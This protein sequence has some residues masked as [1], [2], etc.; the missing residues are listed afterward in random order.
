MRGGRNAALRCALPGARVLLTALTV[1]TATCML[2]M[3]RAVELHISGELGEAETPPQVVPDLALREAG[4]GPA[5]SVVEKQI[6][7]PESAV[8]ALELLSLIR[9]GTVKTDLKT[10][11]AVDTA[12]ESFASTS[13]RLPSQTRGSPP[14][15]YERMAKAR[16]QHMPF[17]VALQR[18]I[19]QC[20]HNVDV[21]KASELRARLDPTKS[22]SQGRLRDHAG[23]GKSADDTSLPMSIKDFVCAAKCAAQ[24]PELERGFQVFSIT[25]Y[26]LEGLLRMCKAGTFPFL[27]WIRKGELLQRACQERPTGTHAFRDAMEVVQRIV[28]I[29]ELP[30]VIFGFDGNDYAVPQSPNPLKYNSA[31]WIQPL[32]QVVRFVGT[33]ASPCPLFPTPPFLKGVGLLRKSSRAK[34]MALPP[35]ESRSSTIF[36]RGGSTGMPFDPDFVYMM[37]RPELVR[38]HRETV[39]FD[40]GLT[41]VDGVTSK[42]REN[43]F[44]QETRLAP[45]A[46]KSVFAQHRYLLHVDGNTASWGL[47]GKLALDAVVLWQ[48][49]PVTF[50]EH[51]YDLLRPWEHY[52]PV[53]ANL[54]NLELVR[55]WLATAAG[56][57]E[58]ASIRDRAKALRDARLR[59]EDAACYI[60]R[61]VHSLA[62]VQAFD[63]AS[64]AHLDRVGA[65]LG[66]SAASF[67]PPA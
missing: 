6:L 15:S 50:R 52:V 5:L 47:F 46:S 7:H 38:R 17:Y 28:N 59:L 44:M 36:W 8:E 3:Q 65:P 22:S 26:N 13:Q 62:A 11:E 33:D 30:S 31:G 61:L 57:Q 2:L 34:S 67:A 66:V 56:A 42:M 43:G 53:D 64:A 51:Y 4:Y 54:G 1:L 58:A 40:V 21:V 39:G 32:A 10:Q 9:N 37:P 16:R 12:L 23:M 19:E 60:V 20:P 35:W 27:V 41:T 25:K 14:A 18:E 48:R 63:A 29:V 24:E 45:F 55:D 49:S